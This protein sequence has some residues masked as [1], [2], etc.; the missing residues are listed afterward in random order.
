MQI[1]IVEQIVAYHVMLNSFSEKS[2]WIRAAISQ[3]VK[4]GR[5]V[6]V[7]FVKQSTIDLILPLT[8]FMFLSCCS[9]YVAK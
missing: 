8:K 5:A 1:Y 2:E 4:S 3:F 9:A 6:Y 7:N